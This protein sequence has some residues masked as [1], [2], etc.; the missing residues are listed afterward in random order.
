M[1]KIKMSAIHSIKST[2]C[3]S[4]SVFKIFQRIKMSFFLE[5]GAKYRKKKLWHPNNFLFSCLLF[6]FQQHILFHDSSTP[7]KSGCVLHN[8]VYIEKKKKNF[9][10]LK[11]LIQRKKK[12]PLCWTDCRCYNDKPIVEITMIEIYQLTNKGSILTLFLF[13][14]LNFKMN[15]YREKD[16][17]V[18]QK[19][20]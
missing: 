12:V 15:T 19:R 8:Y 7:K 4:Q 14:H 5:N 10:S 17:Y 9:V 6:L 16:T 18:I 2:Y 1:I 11:H 13:L 3:R 20:I